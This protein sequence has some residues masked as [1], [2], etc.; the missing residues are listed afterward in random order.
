MRAQIES[1]PSKGITPRPNA[2]LIL[3]ESGTPEVGAGLSNHLFGPRPRALMM[4]L[5]RLR[6][7]NS[8]CYDHLMAYFVNGQSEREI[9]AQAMPAVSRWQIASS[10][11]W[12]V[13]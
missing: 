1:D 7:S 13:G 2:P 12:G 5:R 6:R 4:A 10:L 3:S 9:A 11:K 8:A